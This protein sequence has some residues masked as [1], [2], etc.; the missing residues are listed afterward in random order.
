MGKREE[1]ALGKLIMAEV[2]RKDAVGW[3][4]AW[5]APTLPE[6]AG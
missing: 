3:L 4:R 2:P 6:M 5:W 1:G